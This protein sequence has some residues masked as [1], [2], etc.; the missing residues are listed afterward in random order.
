MKNVR[1]LLRT[2][3]LSAAGVAAM[4][5]AQPP[6]TTSAPAAAPSLPQYVRQAPKGAPNIVLVLLDDV[7]F[8]ATSTF[9]GPA[10]TTTLDRLARDGLRYNRFHTTAICS[11]TRASLLTGRNPHAT[12]IGSVMNSADGRPGY[13]GFQGKDTATIARILR[14]NGYATGAFGKWHQTPDW[15][16]SQAGPFDRWPTGEGF[17]TFYGFQ[18]GETDQFNP[19][20]YQGTTP[21]MRPAGDNYHLTEDLAARAADWVHTIGSSAPG[22]PFFLYFA[23]GGIHAPIQVPKEWIDKYR[24]KFDQGW[25]KMREEIFARQKKLG[26]IPANTKLTPRPAEM[27]TWDSLTPEQKRFSSRLM[28]SYAAFLAHTDAQVGKLVDELKANGQFDNTL[29]IYVVGDN[30]ASAEGGLEGSL[31]YMGRL[32]GVSP[33]PDAKS[34]A[35]IDEIGGPS[36]YAHVN[37]AWAWASD[38]PFQWTKTVAS[39]LGGTRNGMVLSWPNRI[40]QKGGIRSQF[41]HVNDIVPTIL[42]VTGIPTPAEVDGVRQKPMNGVSLAYS[43]NDPKARERHTTQYFEVFGNRA[44]YHDGWMASAFHGRYPWMAYAP[45]ERPLE[46]DEWELYDLRTDFSQSNDLAAKNPKK[47]EELKALFMTEAAANQLLPLGGQVLDKGRLP[48]PTGGRRAADYRQGDIGVP[49]VSLPRLFSRSWTMRA[50]IDATPGARGVVA[51]LGGTDSGM[52]LYLDGEGRPKFTYRLYDVKTVDLVGPA[53]LSS[54][55]HSIQ[56]DFDYAGGGFGKGG[57]LKMTVDDQ[58]IASDTIPA[59]P[60]FFSIHET[61]GVGLDTGAPVGSYPADAP[62]GYPISRAKVDK[63]TI[64]TR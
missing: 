37:S 25:D 35:R 7:G 16:L 50:T 11:P 13:S 19:T 56:V 28:E 52:A 31:D 46:E 18:G 61:F 20:L 38:T 62:L 27:P 3:A 30:G 44:I 63:V 24:G 14:E 49:E 22:Q 34:F 6:A 29:F 4:A 43:F 47:L 17:D 54:G 39:H 26:V 45:R 58:P 2:L 10:Q 48:D 8:G 60:V 53:P 9:G 40:E 36:T 1:R 23:P 41:G 55:K 12:G 59:N 21:V 57:T 33:S 5:H 32:T 15:E 42:E 51:A 64:R